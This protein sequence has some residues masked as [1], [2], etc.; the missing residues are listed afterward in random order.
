MTFRDFALFFPPLNV[1]FHIQKVNTSLISVTGNRK[2]RLYF[3][4]LVKAKQK[5]ISEVA[6][7]QSKAF[8]S[9]F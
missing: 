8:K 2:I 7:C 9:F 1:N 4:S 3:S 5:L 6:I